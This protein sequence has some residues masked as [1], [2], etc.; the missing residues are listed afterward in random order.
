MT[1]QKTL[2]MMVSN[3]SEQMTC[4]RPWAYLGW[5]TGSRHSPSPNES[6]MHKSLNLVTWEIMRAAERKI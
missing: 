6:V 2:M 1:I 4:S 5:L 3:N